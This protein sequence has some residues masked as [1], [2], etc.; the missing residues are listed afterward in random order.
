MGGKTYKGEEGNREGEGGGI[1][2]LTRSS[3]DAC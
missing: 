2:Q 3:M 1:R